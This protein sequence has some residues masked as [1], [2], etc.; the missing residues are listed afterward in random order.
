MNETDRIN[1][2]IQGFIYQKPHV[3][4]DVLSRN[5][6][7]MSNKVTLPEITQKTFTAIYSDRNEKFL[8]ELEDAIKTNGESNFVGIAI[9]SALSI[10]SAIFG[11]NQAKKQR[12][13]QKTIAIAN[14]ENDKLLAEEE[15]R[16]YGELGRT[17]ILANTL[18][19]YR[20]ALQG[21]ST[22]RQ[23][24]VY[25]YILSIGT[26]LSIMYGTFLLLKES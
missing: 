26:A 3:V 1:K 13:L 23:K 21:E 11:S 12:E 2:I 14:L 25:V 15:L 7:K 24:N 18:L 6:Y 9:A 10:G 16:I 22:A 19:A 5:N 20:N 17:E 8:T 4:A